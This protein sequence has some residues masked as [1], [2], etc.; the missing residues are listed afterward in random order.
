MSERDPPP[1]R[2]EKLQTASVTIASLGLNLNRVG[3]PL[4]YDTQNI[5]HAMQES[6][7]LKTFHATHSFLL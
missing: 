3:R 2:V 6:Y 4:K 5:T 1:P 7:T